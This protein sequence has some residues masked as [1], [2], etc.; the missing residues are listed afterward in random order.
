MGQALSD[1]AVE[2]HK[3]TCGSCGATVIWAVSYGGS[4][5]PF[6]AE[7]DELAGNITLT[8]DEQGLVHATVLQHGARQPPLYTSHFVD[9][10]YADENG[11][12]QR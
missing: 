4:K 2:R 8:V 1:P 12:R 6:N 10:P 7:P 9:C 5:I 11:R 3:G